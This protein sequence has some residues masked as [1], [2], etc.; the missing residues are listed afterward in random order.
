[1]WEV[2]EVKSLGETLCSFRWS[3]VCSWL[4]LAPSPSSISSSRLSILASPNSCAK[5]RVS[6]ICQA[7]LCRGGRISS[8]SP[9]LPRCSQVASFSNS[10]AWKRRCRTSWELSSP[11]QSVRQ[12]RK[13]YCML[14]T[15]K[16]M[17]AALMSSK[18]HL[19]DYCTIFQGSILYSCIMLR[20]GGLWLQLHYIW[21]AK[22]ELF[23]PLHLFISQAPVTFELTTIT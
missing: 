2:T 8:N 18:G 22:I 20:V 16:K 3:W 6:T 15:V 21:K 23:A 1:M 5:W 7:T 17:K 10:W 11:G 12:S 13:T 4:S 19:L 9:N 14:I